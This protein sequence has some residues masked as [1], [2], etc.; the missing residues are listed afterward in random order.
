[1]LLDKL[2]EQYG[3]ECP[4]C[5]SD[6]RWHHRTPNGE[7]CPLTGRWFDDEIKT[8]E[9]C[10]IDEDERDDGPWLDLG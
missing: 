4:Y 1:M 7:K 2:R 10:V 9:S 6:Y 5:H 8:K 3:R